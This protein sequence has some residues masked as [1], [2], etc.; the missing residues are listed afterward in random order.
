MNE[1]KCCIGILNDYDNT[2]M[3]TADGLKQHIKE[4]EELQKAFAKDTMWKGF[5]LGIKVWTLADYCDRRKNTDLT[6]F[7]HCPEC[8]KKIDW[9]ALKGGE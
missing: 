5:D 3:I 2:Q 9:K 6:R 8:G 1:H 7:K 4:Q